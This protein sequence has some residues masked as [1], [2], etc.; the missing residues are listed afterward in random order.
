VL[1]DECYEPVRG[2]GNFT[3]PRGKEPSITITSG[4]KRGRQQDVTARGSDI[5]RSCKL[6]SVLEVAATFIKA[7]IQMAPAAT[8]LRCPSLGQRAVDFFEG[9]ESVQRVHIENP[10]ARRFAT[11]DG[12]V[13][14]LVFVREEHYE[15]LN[16]AS[17][18]LDPA[19]GERVLGDTLT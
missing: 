5:Q 7:E 19:F 3:F 9:R 15:S 4:V 8:R 1:G 10:N 13:G 12:N 16:V 11:S 17:G 18:V 14:W 2:V 6:H